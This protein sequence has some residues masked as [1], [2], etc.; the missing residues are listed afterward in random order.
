MHWESIEKRKAN[1]YPKE[2]KSIA[3]VESVQLHS[4]VWNTNI[5]HFL[6]Q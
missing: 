4:V 3:S 5:I 6:L 2:Y 1:P